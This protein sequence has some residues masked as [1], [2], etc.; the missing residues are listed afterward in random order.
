MIANKQRTGFRRL[1]LLCVSLCLSAPLFAQV[2][3]KVTG[4]G[5][6][7]NDAIKDALA[8]AVRQVNGTTVET[9]TYVRQVIQDSIDGIKA[10]FSAKTED[11]QHIRTASKGFVLNYE[12]LESNAPQV[13]A[14]VTLRAT[15]VDWDPENPR[16]GTAKTLTVGAFSMSKGALDFDGTPQNSSALLETLRDELELKIHLGSK[17]AQQDWEQLEAK[18]NKLSAQAGLDKSAEG[19]SSALDLLKDE[20]AQGYER[21][22]KA[23]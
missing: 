20:L 14:V 4:N 11:F 10:N 7:E 13:P 1:L 5:P 15:V 18:W 16:P 22:K 19:I 3:T 12:V 9:D 8:E 23:L 21:L 6:T 2:S 17:E